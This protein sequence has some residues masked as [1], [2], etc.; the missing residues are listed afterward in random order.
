VNRPIAHPVLAALDTVTDPDELAVYTALLKVVG[1]TS[2]LPAAGQK[3][4]ARVLQQQGSALRHVAKVVTAT[5]RH[6]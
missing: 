1:A 5:E 4:V 6:K 3:R 2:R